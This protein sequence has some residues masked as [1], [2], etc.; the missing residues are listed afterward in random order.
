MRFV[1]VTLFLL[2]IVATAVP[3]LV[4]VSALQ[5][6][7]LISTP[8]AQ[9]TPQD[10][11]RIRVWAK[12]NNPNRLRDGEIASSTIIQRDLNL[13]I[14]HVIPLAYR[15]YAQ[16]T[17][18]EGLA[19]VAYTFRLPTN[20]IGQYLNVAAVLEEKSGRIAPAKIEIGTIEIPALVWKPALWLADKS[21]VRF[22]PEYGDARKALESVH[23]RHKQATLVYRWDWNLVKKIEQRGRDFFVSPQDR[24]RAI[25][26][27][28]VLSKT[29]HDVGSTAPLDILLQALFDEAATRS[30]GGD[31]AAENRMMLLVMGTVLRRTDILRVI[32]GDDEGLGRQHRYVKWTLHRRNDLALHFAVSAAVA[33]TSTTELA[34]VVGVIKELYDADV[35]SGFSFVDL[36]A[37]R[38]GVE[39]ARAATGEN[40][41]KTQTF[42][43]SGA[44]TE[45]NF[46]PPIDNLPESLMAIAFKTRY[47]NLDDV[48]YKV[49][50]DEIDH[51]IAQLKVHQP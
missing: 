31:A 36:L 46:M 47:H 14:R 9:L 4:V 34:D 28:R 44:M 27:Y 17:L 13:A 40:A 39:L 42:M 5:D 6:E 38:A 33:T 30:R 8:T 23:L 15:Q 22:W 21:L 16:V 25:A 19:S 41:R 12:N 49:V 1:L 32:G 11:E 43:R 29:S 45:S 51:R 50:K 37:D 35:G 18:T 24:V 20:S 7:P 3:A 48:R 2:L 10:V 26:Y